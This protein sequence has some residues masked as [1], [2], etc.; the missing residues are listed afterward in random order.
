M[1][2]VAVSLS[3]WALFAY[4]CVVSS[5]SSDDMDACDDRYDYIGYGYECK[6][7]DDEEY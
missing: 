6:C 2:Y 1:R 3:Y 4:F 5:F 7:W